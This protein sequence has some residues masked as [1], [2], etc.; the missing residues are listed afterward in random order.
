MLIF[1]LEGF[2][3]THFPSFQ[4]CRMECQPQLGLSLQ[5]LFQSKLCIDLNGYCHVTAIFGSIMLMTQGRRN[6]QDHLH[7]T[8]DKRKKNPQ[9]QMVSFPNYFFLYFILDLSAKTCNKMAQNHF[10]AQ[11]T[12]TNRRKDDKMVE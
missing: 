11:N 3:F 8:P 10:Y 12:L 7:H 4:Y 9:H 6:P 5:I 2:I 1:A